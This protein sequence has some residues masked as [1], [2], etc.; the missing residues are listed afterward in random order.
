MVIHRH[1]P[2]QG[3]L[4]RLARPGESHHGVKGAGAMATTS[5]QT[6]RGSHRAGAAVESLGG[7]LYRFGG[8]SYLLGAAAYPLGGVVYLLGAAARGGWF[9]RHT[10]PVPWPTR[11]VAPSPG[12]FASSPARRAAKMP[13]PAGRRFR[14]L[15]R[16][17][18]GIL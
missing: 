15:S 3:R 13:P 10:E 8:V 18:P 5:N 12:S 9:A 11:S 16:I 14:L 7:D 17:N 6:G 2:H 4:P 1:H